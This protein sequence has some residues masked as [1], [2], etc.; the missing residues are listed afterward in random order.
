MMLVQVND[1][2][3]RDAVCND[4]TPATYYFRR[5]EGTGSHRWVIH[6]QG[7][8]FC[9]SVETCKERS[10][11]ASQLMTSKGLPP[12]RMGNGVQSLSPNDNPD[13]FN[14]N[15]VY[16]PYCSSDVW[17]GDRG[18]APESGGWHFRGARIVRAVIGDL[19]NPTITL[20][21]NLTVAKEVLFSGSSAG[22]VGVMANLDWVADQLPQ[23]TVRG[24]VDAG[25]AIDIAPYDSSIAPLLAQTQRGYAFWNS[26]LDTSCVAANS[27]AEGRCYTEYAYPYI[28][29]PLFVQMAQFDPPQLQRLGITPPLDENERAYMLEFAAAMRKSLESVQAAFS[30]AITTHGI[31]VNEQFWT[32]RI[33]GQSL[34]DLLG[35]WFFGR[36][37]PI[38]LIEMRR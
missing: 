35:N 33:A 1:A 15:H 22:G 8:G 17:S 36:P 13:F 11:N 37:G 26:A 31:L 6:L 24:L 7:G 25:W 21:P 28:S 32:L 23:A 18:A 30:P 10:V 38:K 20:S 12:T 3:A 4:G 16:V 34:R 29:T 9:N 2:V 27:D 14:A 19:M 5:G